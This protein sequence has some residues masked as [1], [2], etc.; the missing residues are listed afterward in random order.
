MDS[1]QYRVA[2]KIHVLAHKINLEADKILS[3]IELNLNGYKF[4]H[5]LKH[6]KLTQ[7]DLGNICGIS[8]AASSKQ[9][10]ILTDARYLE[11]KINPDNRRQHIIQLTKKGNS[12][13][14]EADLL[15]DNMA[16]KILKPGKNLKEVE[17]K[18]D[19]VLKP[20]MCECK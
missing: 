13:L 11:T 9:I 6:H 12:I 1:I 7:A 20:Y 18:L 19:E 8:P 5:I 15:L 4:L 3:K 16:K 2:H 17:E 10:K 14:K